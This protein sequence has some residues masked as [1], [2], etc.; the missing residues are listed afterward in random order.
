MDNISSNVTAISLAVVMLVWF[1][2]AGTFLLGFARNL[3]M[4]KD[5]SA[6]G[7][8]RANNSFIGIALQGLG[9]GLVW[10]LQRRPFLSPLIE[11]QY[12]LNIILQILAIAVVIFSIWLATSAIRELGKQWSFAAR[13]IEE[14]KLV[15]SGVYRIVRHPIYTAML[16]MLLATGIVFTHW[17]VLI[18]AV[19]V[20]LVGTRIRTSAE[21]KLLRAAFPVEYDEFAAR[22]PAL[23]PFVKIF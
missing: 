12:I 14:H 20:F 10:A 2:F 11:D 17:I 3:V 21:E 19:I 23:V 9:F 1:I 15:T 22:I 4:K 18:I 5:D 7:K 8:T 13:L 6:R 16:G